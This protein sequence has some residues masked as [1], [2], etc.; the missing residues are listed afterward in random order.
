MTV[1]PLRTLLVLCLPFTLAG[2]AAADNW[3]AWRGPH[4][5]SA[6]REQNVPFIWN[7]QINVQ[8][9]APL[10][11]P[12]ASTPA[13][14]QDAVFVTCQQDSALLL[15]R[16]NKKDGKLVWR[17]DV[18]QGEIARK[19]DRG[20]QKFH[21]LH[22]LASPSPVTDG[23]V[24]VVH[25]GNGLLAAYDFSGQQLWKRN[26][27]EDHGDYT[28]WWG[29]A[30]SP[31]LVGDLV[32]SVC[33][34][35]SL[36]DQRDKL[37]NSYLVAHDKRTGRVKWLRNRLTG[38]K[39][40]QGDSYTTPILRRIG[41][42]V[43]LIVMGGNVLDAYD[44]LTG[45]QRWSLPDLNGGRT[46]TGPTYAGGYVFT[47]RGMRGDLLAVQ[48]G[49]EEGAR[50]ELP[51]RA[52]RWKYSDGTPDS[53][54]PVVW[55]DLLFTIADNGIARCV[56]AATGRLRWKHRV[57]GSYK[58]SPVAAE[59]RVYFLNQ[60]GLCTVVS[61]S[62]RYNKLAENQLDDITIASPAISDHRVFI[63][64]EKSLYCIER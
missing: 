20:A 12:G 51:R 16:L 37:A 25:F 27:Q 4:G 23:E 2:S 34:Q 52:I 17:Q 54:C 47:T 43:E 14:W 62:T 46:I 58:A 32:I 60:S 38:A 55:G 41:D 19:A 49:Q 10:P 30:N 15:L 26:L 6:C 53:C 5:D 22:N 63:R 61:A 29:H 31:V 48:I 56:D 8:W 44:P 7:E 57:D 21:R 13:I 40:E 18:G 64:G 36:A 45:E 24:V 9:K 28:I 33:M 42:S 39:A 35:D 1:R 11:G 50:G 59:G 3:P